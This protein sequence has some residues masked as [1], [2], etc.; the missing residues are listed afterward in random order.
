MRHYD[1]RRY[2]NIIQQQLKVVLWWK[3]RLDKQLSGPPHT[4]TAG[5]DPVT[6]VAAGAAG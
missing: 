3:L 6:E 4:G 2:S 1:Y 5:S